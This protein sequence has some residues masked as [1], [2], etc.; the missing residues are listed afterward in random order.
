MRVG[1]FF[2]L[3][4]VMKIIFALFCNHNSL[5]VS[6]VLE[7]CEVN[8]FRPLQTIVLMIHFSYLHSMESVFVE[9]IRNRPF[10]EQSQQCPTMYVRFPER[11]T[12]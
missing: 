11:D 7:S 12:S 5:W 9:N 3:A 6:V 10:A 2:F 1:A 8:P 4:S